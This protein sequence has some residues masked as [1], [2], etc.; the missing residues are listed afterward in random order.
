MGHAGE[1]VLV[2][3]HPGSTPVVPV[4][5]EGGPDVLQ[6]VQVAEEIGQVGDDLLLVGFQFHQ[7]PIF[8]LQSS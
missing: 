6:A 3:L 8:R 1:I 4:G 2:A 5:A 7:R